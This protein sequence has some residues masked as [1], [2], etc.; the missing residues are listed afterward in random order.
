[1]VGKT[2]EESV[3]QCNCG[4]VVVGGDGEV[5]QW[6]GKLSYWT[7]FHKLP[8]KSGKGER[9]VQVHFQKY[10]AKK[11]SRFRIENIKS[12][13]INR[14]QHGH[15]DR[16][17]END[18]V[19]KKFFFLLLKCFWLIVWNYMKSE[20]RYWNDFCHQIWNW[21]GW[22]QVKWSHM[23]TKLGVTNAHTYINT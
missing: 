11:M 14:V 7:T 8:L 3:I 10:W 1:M 4:A 20:T 9:W 19:N 22:F 13:G 5:A 15:M 16:E 17:T 12:S 21:N 23:E 18:L 2:W 6:I